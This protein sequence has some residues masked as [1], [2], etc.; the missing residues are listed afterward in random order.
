MS[1]LK[2]FLSPTPKE[3]FLNAVLITGLGLYALGGGLSQC[4]L[5]L[6]FALK[7]NFGPSL[8]KILTVS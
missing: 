8:P 2:K 1:F 3:M 4:L 5:S 7:L 6:I